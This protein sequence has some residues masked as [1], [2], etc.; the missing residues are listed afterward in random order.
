M[1]TR[2]PY[3]AKVYSGA[4]R[5]SRQLDG[6]V[7]LVVVVLVNSLYNADLGLNVMAS[8]YVAWERSRFLLLKPL[9]KLLRW[10]MKK[11]APWHKA[12]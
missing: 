4:R 10:A 5:L 8:A 9:G 12:A 11:L 7:D 6:L 1:T 3:S 2:W